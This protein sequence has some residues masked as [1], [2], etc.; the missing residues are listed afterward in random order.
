MLCINLDESIADSPATSPMSQ[1]DAGSLSI[2][3]SLTSLQ[4]LSAIEHAATDSNIEGILIYQNGTG[5]I[6]ISLIEELR[7]ALERF[8]LSGKF[9]STIWHL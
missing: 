4:A 8:K 2:N 9:V 1:F 3:S 7:K 5:S 6:E